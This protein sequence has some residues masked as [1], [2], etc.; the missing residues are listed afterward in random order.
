MQMGVHKIL[1][2]PFSM[3]ELSSLLETYNFVKKK[4]FQEDF[5]MRD[6]TSF[7]MKESI[8]LLERE[9]NIGP[10][11]QSTYQYDVHNFEDSDLFL[12]VYHRKHYVFS[13]VIVE[14][15]PYH[16]WQ[17]TVKQI[18]AISPL[19]SLLLLMEENNI[20]MAVE[21][22]KI[23]ISGVLKKSSETNVILDKMKEIHHTSI[24]SPR[25]LEMVQSWVSEHNL[26]PSELLKRLLWKISLHNKTSHENS[27][28]NFFY[29]DHKQNLSL[30]I[31]KKYTESFLK[32]RINAC[33]KTKILIVEDE[34]YYRKLI[35]YL[36]KP[37]LQGF[38]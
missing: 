12:R 10:I 7:Y 14:E 37:F 38:L 27:L 4:S 22:A 17:T 30:K 32:K 13:T 24:T 6:S 16:H 1:K 21:G 15:N 5:L 36:L 19:P 35:Y 31:I 23:G 34:E 9:K 3:V 20:N 18:I 26:P 33:P 28:L 8:L 2:K 29:T 25:R 11:L